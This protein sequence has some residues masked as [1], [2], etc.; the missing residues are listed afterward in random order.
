MTL[1]KEWIDGLLPTFVL[2]GDGVSALALKILSTGAAELRNPA[3]TAYADLRLRNLQLDGFQ[4]TSRVFGITRRQAI[5]QGSINSSTGLPNSI[6]APGGLNAQINA[7]AT[8][9]IICNFAA[10]YDA[11]GVPI[12]YTGIYASVQ[13]FNALAANSVH[14]FYLE[15]NT[16]T[17]A[18]TPTRITI[19]P[20][21]AR[22]APS[23]PSVGL[24]W[25][26]TSQDSLSTQPGYQMYEWTG[27]WT[28]RQRVFLGEIATGASSVTSVANYAYGRRYQ[29]PWTAV[30]A[31]SS[32]NFSH[33]L[34][35]TAAE[36]E[37]SLTF[38][39][40]QNS[41]DPNHA[42]VPSGHYFTD[43]NLYGVLCLGAGSRINHPFTLGTAGIYFSGGWLP[44]VDLMCCINSGW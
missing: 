29:S 38:Y 6:T 9:P 14:Y 13:G 17:G 7:S 34:G 23:S 33:S 1:I 30:S 21:Y 11:A 19:A 32:I 41:S 36:A 4:A 18:L 26:K 27:A 20:V 40:R 2:F 5:A 3:D 28:P 22:V 16:S 24:H 25:F 15:R 12:D 31:S 43:G 39:G 42:I 35:M 10:G 44:N 8:N 37:A